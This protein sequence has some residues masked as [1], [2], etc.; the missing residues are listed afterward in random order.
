M[1]S[2]ES[3][4]RR[5]QARGRHQRG[6]RDAFLATLTPHATLTDDGNTRSLRDWIDREHGVKGLCPARLITS[7][8]TA[9]R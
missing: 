8:S 1:T 4:N 2:P 7:L 5:A 3:S 6:D 9:P